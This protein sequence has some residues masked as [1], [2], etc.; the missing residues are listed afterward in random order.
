MEF[1]M[2]HE[3]Y[4]EYAKLLK[5]SVTE[6]KNGKRVQKSTKQLRD[7]IYAYIEKNKFLLN[8]SKT[9]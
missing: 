5:I 2:S 6:K 7:D 4:K 1:N 8:D 3:R 9:I